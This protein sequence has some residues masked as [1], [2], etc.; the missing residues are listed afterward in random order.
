MLVGISIK[1]LHNI[2]RAH[3]TCLLIL[4]VAQKDGSAEM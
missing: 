2:G 1:L 4:L 3:I